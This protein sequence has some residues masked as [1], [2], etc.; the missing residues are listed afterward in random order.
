MLDH[1]IAPASLVLYKQSPA[2]VT[3]VTDKIDIKLAN[4]KSKR[5]RTKDIVLLHPGP[6]AALAELDLPEGELL[7]AWEL[8]AG[9]CCDLEELAALIYGEFS[10]ASAWASW[11]RVAEGLYFEGSPTS[12]RA[13]SN[14]SSF[15]S[16]VLRRLGAWPGEKTRRGCGRNVITAAVPSTRLA[17]STTFERRCWWPRCTPSKLPIVS[18][19][20]GNEESAA[21]S[22]VPAAKR[23]CSKVFTTRRRTRAS[24]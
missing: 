16:S 12:I 5:V 4:A 9:E 8:L 14:N 3:A 15:C 22:G 21:S 1:S 20:C 23:L 7:E 2:T 19:T 24:A 11:Q 10:P 17:T 18:T 13:R 6:V